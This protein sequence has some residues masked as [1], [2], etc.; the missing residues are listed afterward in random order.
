VTAASQ[1]DNK[2]ILPAD[3]QYKA[4]GYDLD[5]NNLPTFRYKAFGATV[6]DQIRITD[7]KYLM[8]TLT[9][10]NTASVPLFSRLAIGKSITKMDNNVYSIDGKS[11]FIQLPAGVSATIQ[12]S[13]S[14]DILL[15][16][17]KDKVEYAIMW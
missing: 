4:L 10:K 15:V 14:D 16:P 9:L 13:G 11:Y 7:N 2:D 3:A 12:K 8:R 5:D 6:E 1:S 17:V